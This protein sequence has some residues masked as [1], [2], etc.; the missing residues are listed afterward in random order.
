[1]AK[2]PT[3]KRT[4]T[5][6]QSLRREIERLEREKQHLKQESAGQLAAINKSQ[7]VIEFETDG[8]IITANDNFL[9]PMGYTL[10]EV[11]GRHH[12]MFV[13][14]EYRSSAEYKDFWDRL[15][16]GEYT[17]GQY[18]RLANEFIRHGPVR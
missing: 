3:R 10:E 1:M 12:S 15:A 14:P 11:Q 8:T 7:A 4:Q 9:T 18:K 5:S 16:R 2:A 6:T 13:S 17:V